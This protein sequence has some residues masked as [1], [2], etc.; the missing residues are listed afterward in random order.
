VITEFGWVESMP[1]EATERPLLAATKAVWADAGNRAVA[2]VIARQKTSC[3]YFI[4]K[5]SKN[6]TNSHG[7]RLPHSIRCTSLAEDHG[8]P[9][10]TVGLTLGEQSRFAKLQKE[11]LEGHYRKQLLAQM[12]NPRHVSRRVK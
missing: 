1:G 6:C 2:M 12:A 4:P 7:Q 11:Y 9:N 5:P 8:C 10:L 3:V